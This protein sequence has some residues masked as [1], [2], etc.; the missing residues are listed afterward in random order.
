MNASNIPT[1]IEATRWAAAAALLA[2][3]ALCLAWEL[4]LAPVRPG[5]SWLA[6]KALP[7][8][9]PLAGVLKR[10]MYTYRWLSLALWLYFAEGLVRATS[11]NGP[12]VVL[13]WL[14]VIL[15]LILFGCCVLHIRWRQKMARMAAQNP[16]NTTPSPH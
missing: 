15:C 10:R 2:L 13:A 4:W 3:I 1:P 5:G 16:D 12:V 9:W 7:L 14:E 6:L 8:A 11:E